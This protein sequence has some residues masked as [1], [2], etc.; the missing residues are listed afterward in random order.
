MYTLL[1]PKTGLWELQQVFD[2]AMCRSCERSTE[3][4]WK[5]CRENEAAAIRQL[6]DALRS[7]AEG[8]TILIT[9]GIREKGGDFVDAALKVVAAFDDFTLDNDPRNEHDFGALEIHGEKIFFKLDYFDESMTTHSPDPTDPM[10]TRR[11]MTI[12]LAE[13]Y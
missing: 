6:N 2:Q 3:F 9:A 1:V 13:E 5:R 12:M 8:G 7:R 11:V 10:L 4:V